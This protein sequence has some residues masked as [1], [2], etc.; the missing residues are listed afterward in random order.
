MP[1]QPCYHAQNPETTL[2]Q[3]HSTSK[4]NI[5]LPQS[6]EYARQAAEVR[7]SPCWTLPCQLPIGVR[8]TSADVAMAPKNQIQGLR[9]LAQWPPLHDST[10][11]SPLVGD[12]ESDPCGI[13][14]QYGVKGESVLTA[15]VDTDELSCHVCGFKADTLELALLHQQQQLERHFQL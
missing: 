3:N 8:P 5:Q 1:Y 4:L 9:T 12:I 6:C 15:F 7:H 10:T 14:D 13:A 2:N 11:P